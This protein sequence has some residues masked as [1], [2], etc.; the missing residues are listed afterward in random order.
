MRALIPALLAISVLAAPALAQGT[1]AG[2]PEGEAAAPARSADN[3]AEEM[4]GFLRG[5]VGQAEQ[6]LRQIATT[7]NATSRGESPAQLATRAAQMDHWAGRFSALVEAT[8]PL[9]CFPAD[10][11]EQARSIAAQ[12]GA[13]AAQARDFAMRPAPG[14]E[15]QQQ[16]VSPAVQRRREQRRQQQRE[17][18]LQQSLLP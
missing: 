14:A 10:T 4:C 2:Q 17:Q 13:F 15:Q 16:Q 18:E 8:T 5:Q 12:Y 1:D 3:L 7:L 9:N 11:L 6:M